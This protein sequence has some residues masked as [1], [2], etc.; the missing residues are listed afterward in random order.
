MTR[1]A[2]RCFWKKLSCS[3]E[4]ICSLEGRSYVKEV[5]ECERTGKGA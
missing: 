2:E 4:L 1:S 5:E 3:G